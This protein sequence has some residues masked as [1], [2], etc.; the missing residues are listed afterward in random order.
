MGSQPS[1][2]SVLNLDPFQVANA[3]QALNVNLLDYLNLL[4][5]QNAILN[6]A[7]SQYTTNT[8]QGSVSYTQSGTGPGGI[9]LY[10]VNQNLSTANQGLY[11]SFLNN[12]A[13]LGG[14]VPGLSNMGY[15]QALSTGPNMN[16]PYGFLGQAQGTAQQALAGI[17]DAQDTLKQ[18]IGM[19]PGASQAG[20]QALGGIPTVMSMYQ[21]TADMWNYIKP[22]VDYYNGLNPSQVVGDATSGNTQ[23]LVNQ[24]TGYYDPFFTQQSDRLDNM[25]RNQGFAPGTPG[26]DNAMS[27][28]LKSQNAEV[29]KAI[30]QFEPIAYAQAYQN[31]MTP[32]ALGT[33][34]ANIGGTMGSTANALAG[35]IGSMTGAAQNQAQVATALAQMGYT[36][37]QISGI[38]NEIAKTQ[39]GLGQTATNAVS[40]QGSLADMLNK[41]AI[42]MTGAA[43]PQMP[44]SIGGPQLS[45]PTPSANPASLTSAV[46]NSQN[47][48][49]NAYNAQNQQ[50]SNF[51]SGLF[52]IGSSLLPLAFGASDRRLKENIQELGV[53]KNGLPFYSFNYLW[54][55]TPKIG[56]MADEVELIHPEAVIEVNGYKMV[57]YEIAVR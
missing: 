11:N 42:A 2:P 18:A 32:L 26:Y 12:Q 35:G 4:G 47:A 19:I 17:P 48:Q 29:G 46:A 5:S 33:G 21:P 40:T 6:Q 41:S 45:I 38:M 3:Q 31:F 39:G 50:N 49:L 24:M 55:K 52:G 25:L 53:L 56:L 20:Q 14:S 43:G 44:S 37:A 27:N 30:A 13:Y 57:N 10:T 8:P 9:P 1:V 16:I 23:F 28:M 22:Q 36:Q 15:Q 51:L 34:M 54:D 7:G